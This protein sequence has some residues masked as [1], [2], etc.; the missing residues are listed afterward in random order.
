VGAVRVSKRTPN[1]PRFPYLLKLPKA[2][3]TPGWDGEGLEEV[4]FYIVYHY[5]KHRTFTGA[6]KAEVGNRNHADIIKSLGRLALYLISMA[7]K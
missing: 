3:V 5:F 1:P 4:S 7:L 6:Y 2:T